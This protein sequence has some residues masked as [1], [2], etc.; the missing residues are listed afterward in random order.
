MSDRVPPAAQLV[1]VQALG[2]ALGA[3]RVSTRIP[4]PR[5]AEHV[6][7]SRI[8]GDDPPFG[9]TVPRFLV[10]CYASTELKAEELGEIVRHRWCRLR[11]RT[12]NWSDADPLVPYD[13]PDPGH[14]RFQFTGSLQILL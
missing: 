8:G 4:D 9:A 5:P 13:S 2:P 12:I 14:F 11:S 10:E 1:A 7:V 3:V 6:V